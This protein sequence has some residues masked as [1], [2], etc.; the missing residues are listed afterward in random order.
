MTTGT[1]LE[2]RRQ[3]LL[4]TVSL[5]RFALRGDL[6]SL[7]ASVSPAAWLPKAVLAVGAVVVQALLAKRLQLAGA[8]GVARLVPVAASLG[9]AALLRRLP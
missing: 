1:D 2:A 8:P 4:A 7:Q 3:V 6:G 5:Q 9:V